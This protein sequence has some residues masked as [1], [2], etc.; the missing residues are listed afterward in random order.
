[1]IE[2]AFS[3]FYAQE[4]SDQNYQLYIVYNDHNEV[5]YVGISTKN[6]W[7]RWFGYGG[8]M[9]WDGKVIYGESPIG[10]KIEDHLPNSLNWKIQLWTLQDCLDFC[11]ESINGDTDTTTIINI[12]PLMVQKMHPVLN[13]T[14]N[15]SP[16]KDSTQQSRKE[17]ER[18][19]R[20]DKLYN[21]TFN[22]KG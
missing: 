4:Y 10:M 5:L 12:E 21:D 11:I 7:E 8:H 1:M 14:Y 3:Q 17:R 20:A 22:K 19:Q 6:I 18:Q 2:L 9:V 13:A 15:H 16:G